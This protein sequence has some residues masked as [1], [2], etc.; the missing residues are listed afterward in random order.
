MIRELFSKRQKALRGELPDVYTYSELSR[1][2]RVQIIHIWHD[3]LGDHEASVNVGNPRNAYEAIASALSREYGFFRLPQPSHLDTVGI[4]DKYAELCNFFLQESD[5]ERV[6]DVIELSFRAI[7]RLARRP[8][9]LNRA[10]A[11]SIADDAIQELNSRFREHGI[12]YE[13]VDGRIIR[14]DS[15]LLHSEVLRPTL[16]LLAGASEYAG[17]HEEFLSAHQHYRHGRNKEALNECL[18]SLESAMKAIC[19]KRGWAHD[20]NATAHKLIEVLF[21]SRLVP[22]FWQQHFSALRSSLEAGVPTIRNR[23][24]GHG[25]GTQVTEVP[26]HLVGYMLHLTGSAIVF[27]VE[28][29]KALP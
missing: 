13:F 17:A 24:A 21:S 14:I 25:Q 23:L 1:Q 27:L 16:A 5:T 9:Y 26:S 10:D 11:S 18:K 4:N 12:G 15:T 19:A 3:A 22:S 29:E 28:S 7:D 2:L 20:A 8:G 6:L